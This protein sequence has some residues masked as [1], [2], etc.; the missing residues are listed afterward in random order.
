MYY[1]AGI[2]RPLLTFHSANV[3]YCTLQANPACCSPYFAPISKVDSDCT[4]T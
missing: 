3:A 4:L 1:I 2:V